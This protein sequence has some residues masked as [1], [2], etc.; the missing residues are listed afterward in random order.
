VCI[1]CYDEAGRPVPNDA[2]R[3]LGV[4]LREVGEFGG[5]H[6]VVSDWNLEDWHIDS[7]IDDPATTEVERGIMRELKKLSNGQRHAAMAVADD[8]LDLE[9][10]ELC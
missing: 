9:A 10:T 8:L 5:C 7:C 6:I 1:T 2:A 3:A 4:R